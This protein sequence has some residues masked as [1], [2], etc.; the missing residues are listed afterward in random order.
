MKN[1]VNS[2]VDQHQLPNASSQHT[3]GLKARDPARLKLNPETTM[4][5]DHAESPTAESIAAVIEQAAGQLTPD[6]IRAARRSDQGRK[7]LDRMEYALGTIGKALILTDYTI[8][9]DKDIDKLKA[10]RQAQAEGP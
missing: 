7:A 4:S 3:K 5:S 10:F 8:D 2:K 1:A 6:V 9:E